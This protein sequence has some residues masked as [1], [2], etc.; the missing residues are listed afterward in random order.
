M[1]VTNELNRI[2]TL[3]LQKS[4]LLTFIRSINPK[5]IIKSYVQAKANYKKAVKNNKITR[6]V[7]STFN[8]ELNRISTELGVDVNELLQFTNTKVLTLLSDKYAEYDV[9]EYK[10]KYKKLSDR[11]NELK[12]K[13]KISTLGNSNRRLTADAANVLEY[14]TKKIPQVSVLDS[15]ISILEEEATNYQIKGL[16]D[17]YKKTQEVIKS[18]KVRRNEISNKFKNKTTLSPE[19]YK[20][21]MEE[22]KTNPDFVKLN[23]RKRELKREI[24]KMSPSKLAASFNFAKQNFSNTIIDFDD[25]STI[26][27]EQE[28]YNQLAHLEEITGVSRKEIGN[29][30]KSQLITLLKETVDNTTLLKEMDNLKLE[31][32]DTKNAILKVETTESILAEIFDYEN[33][34]TN[35]KI[36]KEVLVANS[37]PRVQRIANNICYKLN[38]MHQYDEALSGGLM[39]LAV[40]VDSWYEKQRNHSSA[41]NFSE[42]SNVHVGNYARRALELINSGG[43]SGSVA[44]NDRHQEKKRR[45]NA[46]KMVDTYLKNHP[47]M[48]DIKD[49]L[50]SEL[51]IAEELNDEK[52]AEK[53]AR[54]KSTKITETDYNGMISGGEGAADMWALSD[55]GKTNYTADEIT[56]A[57]Q[58][59][60]TILESI[61]KLMN[62]FD[63]KQIKGS[64]K[65]QVNNNRKL[66]DV[67]DRKIFLMYFGLVH[68]RTANEVKGDKD[69][70]IN[71]YT[72]RE[73]ADEIVE[74]K[75]ANGDSNP[76]F[77]V[78]SVTARLNN[79]KKK[80][81]IAVDM[82]PKLKKGLEYLL[83]YIDNNKGLMVKLSNDREELSIK[84]DRD[85]I[86]NNYSDNEDVMNIEMIDSTL[87][88]DEYELEYSN[89]LTDIDNFEF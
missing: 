82:N 44:A 87:L 58:T 12:A 77:A 52:L 89:E 20:S 64:N 13:E 45:E 69:S 28:Y 68:K 19:V 18:L 27:I 66:M 84:K 53:S 71:R 80:L 88:G 5:S 1:F 65:Y 35:G 3:E 33:D 21:R 25:N 38:K 30:N 36:P 41:I 74:M 56:D 61:N 70:D 37:L 8:N 83:T 43:R 46:E 79:I 6:A 47:N 34:E 51:L 22:L 4:E 62:L 15:Q 59:Y 55:Y 73:I 42:F 40:A 67:Y 60:N 48:Q 26:E 85:L 10:I 2:E 63:V 9:D 39:G 29:M 50:I 7:K 57:K 78:T 14:Y 11:L 81:K 17:N 49:T 31:I 32:N 16:R 23:K 76:T 72:L 54:L 24:D 86:R 75:R